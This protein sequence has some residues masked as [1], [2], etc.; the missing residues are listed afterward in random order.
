M[1]E[2]L[3]TLHY[4]LDRWMKRSQQTGAAEGPEGW[5]SSAG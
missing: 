2:E 3:R 4:D 5:S 1:I